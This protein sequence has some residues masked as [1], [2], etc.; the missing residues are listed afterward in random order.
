MNGLLLA[1]DQGTSNTKALLVDQTGSIVARA[2]RALSRTYPQPG[3]VEQDPRTILLSVQQAI[4]DVLAQAG[5][6]VVAALAISNQRESVMLWERRGGRPL[7]PCVSWQ[8]RRSERICAE[9]RA[10][11]AET[12]VRSRTGLPLDPMFS[13]GKARWLLDHAPDGIARAEK[14]ELCLGTVDSWLLWSLTAGAVHACD[15]SNAAR[16]Q[17]FNIHDLRW[18]PELLEVFGIP[19]AALPEVRPSGS[20]FGTSAPQGTLPGGVPIA[21]MIGDS[22][23]ALFGQGGFQPGL[24]KATYGT[25]SSLMTP[26]RRLPDAGRGIA[27]T[28][29]WARGDVT[30]ALEGNITVTG[31]A[32]QWLGRLFNLERSSEDVTALARQVPDADGVY[33][34][35]AFA[36][37]GAPHWNT[38]ARG[39]I[40]GL[41]DRTTLAHLARAT[42]DAIVFQVRDVFEAMRACSTEGF[43]ALLA[44]GGPSGNDLLMQLQADTLN[45]PVVRTVSAD[46]SA[47]GAAYLAGLT[48]GYWPSE[49]VVLGLIGPRDRFEPVANSAKRESLYRGWLDALART[50]L[51]VGTHADGAGMEH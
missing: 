25:G 48:I 14:G 11:G 12:L 49:A 45:L 50:T 27:G 16:T 9:V 17:L 31:A 18:D 4:D 21:A 43:T 34:V 33:L 7:G 35:P 37:L 22:H 24:I 32:V 28:I 38:A 2:T 5:P 6:V 44:D 47:I 26:T 29:A 30:Y 15:M 20:V 41:T 10:K 40:C 46:V 3:W 36:G 13:A 42:L 19:A 1:I 39:L 23:A 51:D 8:C